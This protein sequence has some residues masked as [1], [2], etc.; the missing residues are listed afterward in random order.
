MNKIILLSIMLSLTACSTI[1]SR[2]GQSIEVVDSS[3]SLNNCKFVGAVKGGSGYDDYS[4]AKAHA[5]NEIRENAAD[6]NGTHLLINKVQR[7]VL[8]IGTVIEGSVYSC[9]SKS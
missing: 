6:L 5:L 2:K 8:L 9:K 3:V 4:E 1:L 7:R